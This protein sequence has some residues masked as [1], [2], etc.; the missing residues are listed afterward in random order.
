MRRSKVIVNREAY[1]ASTKSLE[2]EAQNIDKLVIGVD[3]LQNGATPPTLAQLL[4]HTKEVKVSLGG[5]I[6]TLVRFD[7]LFALNYLLLDHKPFYLLPVADTNVGLLSDVVLPVELT[8]DKVVKTALE[9]TGHA[10]VTTEKLSLSVK[11]RNKAYN[12]RPICIQSVSGNTKTTFGEHDISLSGKTLLALLIYNTTIPTVTTFD[13]TVAELKML[14]K[15]DEKSHFVYNNIKDGKNWEVENT[16]IDGI[17]ANYRLLDFRDD[18]YPADSLKV[19]VKS[20]VATDA[21]RLVGV[22]R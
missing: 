22:Y 6:F 9:Y 10:T 18:P 16:V 21:F 7:D 5:E 12:S 8:S 14:L 20:L 17:L 15:R 1:I 11:Y 4:A 2:V 19:A 3:F 13:A